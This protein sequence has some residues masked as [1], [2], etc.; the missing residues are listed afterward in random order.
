MKR[1]VMCAGLVVALVFA[2]T[3]FAATRHFSGTVQGGGTVSFATT[4]ENGKTKSVKLPL[5]FN[6]VPISC[7]QGDTTLN[8]SLTGTTL[9]VTNRKFSFVSTPGGASTARITGTFTNKGKNANGTFRDRGTFAG[10]AA[11]GC[12]TGTVNWTAHKV[13]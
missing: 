8:Y 10:G 2:A 9:K 11:T 13:S 6:A 5:K 7:D 1:I 4:F 12:D 3:A